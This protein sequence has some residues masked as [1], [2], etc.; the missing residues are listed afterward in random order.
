MFKSNFAENVGVSK[1][2]LD[3]KL[4]LFILRITTSL[5]H[6][7]Y[8]LLPTVLIKVILDKTN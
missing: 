1:G 2:L 7:V 5:S 3:I 4:E 6:C 8:F